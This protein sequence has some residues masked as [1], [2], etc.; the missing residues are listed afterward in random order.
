MRAVRLSLDREELPVQYGVTA[1][2]L[3]ER[4]FSYAADVVASVSADAPPDAHSIEVETQYEG[5]FFTH[6]AFTPTTTSLGKNTQW[7]AESNTL[8][9]V[10][11][12]D[13]SAELIERSVILRMNDDMFF[14]A[15]TSEDFM[16]MLILAQTPG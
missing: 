9:W 1:G 13:A 15:C 5:V 14:V 4:Y 16:T 2:S 3:V 8:D 7:V 11:I 10:E 6:N 12:R